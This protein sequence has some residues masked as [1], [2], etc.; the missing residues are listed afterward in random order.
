M[1]ENDTKKWGCVYQ[2]VNMKNGMKYIGSTQMR[3]SQRQ[4]RH[5]QDSHKSNI[6]LYKEIR[7]CGIENF[8]IEEL[9]PYF[10]TKHQL[11]RKEG[12]WIRKLDTFNN[13]YNMEIA[14]RTRKEYED[15]NKEQ[16]KEYGKKYYIQNKEQIKEQE[17]KYREEHKEKI[18]EREKE[19]YIQNNK[20]KIKCE[21]GSIVNKSSL[22]RHKKT[23]K[24]IKLMISENQKN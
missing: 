21:C 20:E 18:K 19:Y 9:K 16:K 3:L 5:K 13:G 23:K 1:T 17:K 24:H 7:K 10:L 8:R 4:Y 14:G 6:Y 12:K 15:E 22:I 2:I 11:R